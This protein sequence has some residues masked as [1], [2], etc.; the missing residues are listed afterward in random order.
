MERILRAR[1]FVLVFAVVILTACS[2]GSDGGSTPPLD[3]VVLDRTTAPAGSTVKVDGLALDD[4]PLRTSE[5]RVGG[6]TAPTVLNER[7][8]PLM[9][10][11]LFYDEET[12][13]AAPPTGPQDVEI[14]CNGTLWRT[15]PAAI[16]VTELPPAPGATEAMVSNYQEIVADYKALTEALA[17]EPGIM[18]Q[19]FTATFA[20]LEDLVAGDD[21]NSLPAQL[22]TLKRTEPDVLALMDAVYAVDGIDDAVA[23]FRDHLRG[24]T[25]EVS[26]LGSVAPAATAPKRVGVF[27]F[28]VPITMADT[29]LAQL[30]R[31]HHGVEAFSQQFVAPTAESFGNFEGLLSIVIKSKLASTINTV[32]GM[33]DY[34][35]N[36]LVVS[37]MPS[38]ITKIELDLA[39]TQLGND[40]VTY[41][42]FTV[43]AEN[44]P[45]GLS[46]SDI[47]SV[48]LMTIG[49]SDTDVPGGEEALS[50]IKP[51]EDKL[52]EV[53]KYLLE[54]LNKGFAQWA[55]DYP[56]GADYDMEVFAIIPEMHFEA[57]G[58][59]REL[60]TL[61]P[62]SSNVVSPLANQLEWQASSTYWGSAEVFVAPA[63]GKFGP[64]N[65]ISSKVRVRVGE[66]AL[67]LDRY[68]APVPE[69]DIGTFGVKLSHAVEEPVS[70]RI[71]RVGGDS[72][73]SI[74]SELPLIIDS[75]SW[76][77]YKQVVLAAADDD[78]AEDGEATITASAVVDLDGSEPITIE[79]T[80]VAVEEDD[81]RARFVLEPS[82]VRIP[83][84][85]TAQVGVK[86][87]QAPE[88]RVTAIVT[89]SSG[90]TD[91]VVESPTVMRF[92]EDNW[93]AYQMVT[94]Y[95]HPD[96]D[97]EEGR[98]QLKVSANPPAE[99][100]DNYITAREQEEQEGGNLVVQYEEWNDNQ[101]FILRG[102]IEVELDPDNF[103]LPLRSTAYL[104]ASFTSDYSEDFTGT[105][106]ATVFNHPME[107]AC[108]CGPHECDRF[109][110]RGSPE[111][112]ILAIDG[113]V[114]WDC[115]PGL[116]CADY[117]FSMVLP[118]LGGTTFETFCTSGPYF[119]YSAELRP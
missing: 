19:L 31:A 104:T 54:K 36:K 89:H 3:D 48:I 61:Y 62:D 87:N 114:S 98:A 39:T 50:W 86:L 15:L 46:I 11:P 29:K 10:L 71:E 109:Y 85:E 95:A 77:T 70:V 47:T 21:P 41:S 90:D 13:W 8:E 37:A 22:D 30:M 115:E 40:E 100:D 38:T 45:E 116:G 76:D 107:P 117:G 34:I 6:Q 111:D 27:V 4:C 74:D 113:R 97:I 65:T 118:F 81:D 108:P 102:S 33:L 26:A 42:E 32:L 119:S 35:L 105:G 58:E 99:V 67:Q 60:Y 63:A 16:T 51:F 56:G 66:L 43:Y 25:A 72:D 28:P 88:S 83:E 96:E 7:H 14:F 106:W 23:A 52:R 82:S 103:S 80:L 20:A 69:G 49:L 17:P 68:Q 93:D 5:I 24:L 64:Q 84:D 44:V 91:I 12:K 101:R 94:L 112:T 73:I 9:R 59:T 18:Q 92:D 79:A 2:A 53:T 75:S 78:D 110:Q 1:D 57:R 55:N